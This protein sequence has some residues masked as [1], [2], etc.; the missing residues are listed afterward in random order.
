[1]EFA[2]FFLCCG[3]SMLFNFSL[4]P[5]YFPPSVKEII[6]KLHRVVV[7]NA[8]VFELLLLYFYES[9]HLIS[10][11]APVISLCGYLSS[12]EVVSKN[13][14]PS[15]HGD[16]PAVWHQ[17]SAAAFIAWSAARQEARGCSCCHLCRA[18]SLKLRG[19]EVG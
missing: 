12:S 13:L 1:M 3:L 7:T 15:V 14:G 5:S 10:G 4:K 17:E 2:G 16:Q 9:K 19:L 11:G 8:H 18:C 6:N